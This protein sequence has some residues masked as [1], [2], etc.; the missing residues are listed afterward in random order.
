MQ[1]LYKKAMTESMAAGYDFKDPKTG[2]MVYLQRPGLT[3][4]VLQ[5]WLGAARTQARID[6]EL[7]WRRLRHEES[8]ES[9]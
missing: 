5:R 6:E 8:E 3:K 9:C 7:D 2:E 4:A 1:E